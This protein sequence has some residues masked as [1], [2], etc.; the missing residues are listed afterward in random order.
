[1]NKTIITIWHRSNMGKSSTILELAKLLLIQRTDVQII[2]CS[3]DAQNLTVDFRLIISFKGKII[4]L[5]SQGDP[6]SR[7]GERLLELE[8]FNPSII[9]CTSRTR[10]ETVNAIENFADNNDYDTIWTS[11]YQVSNNHNEFNMLKAMHLMQI[12][13]S[14]K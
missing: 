10:G 1:M 4:A 9:I 11:T 3:K 12:I 14:I 8:T 2:Q 5:E 13:E 6:N 7:L